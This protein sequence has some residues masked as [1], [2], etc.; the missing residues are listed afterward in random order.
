VFGAV[1]SGI[2]IAGVAAQALDGIRRW[3]AFCN[4]VRDA[5]EEIKYL[6]DE[7]E[8]LLGTIASIEAQI[9]RNSAICRNIDPAPALR[10]V[11]QSVTSLNDIIAKFNKEIARKRTL[12]SMKMAWKKKVLESYLMK[13]ERSKTSLGLAVSAHSTELYLQTIVGTDTKTDQVNMNMSTLAIP[14]QTRLMPR[15]GPQTIDALQIVSSQQLGVDED[16]RWRSIRKRSKSSNMSPILSF[17]LVLPSWLAQHSLKISLC[18]AAQSWTLRLR[19]YREVSQDCCI[20]KAISD[21]D[22]DWFRD[23]I[24]SG[25]AT[26]FDRCDYEGTLLHTFSHIA[27]Y[28]INR[29]ADV[30]EPNNYGR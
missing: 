1:A 27:S 23:L 18:R 15:L 12:G 30:N 24:E 22:F 6:T 28:L 5:P 29:G 4:D 17:S 2:G 3:K 20:W 10:F 21:G 13:I 7:L 25:Q 11:T 14:R 8:I 26:V 9:Q 19:P 16:D